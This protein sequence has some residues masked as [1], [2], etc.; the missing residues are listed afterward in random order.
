MG[1]SAGYVVGF[2]L[3]A[4]VCGH[5]AVRGTDRS[6]L[7][8]V[9]TMLVGE[10]CIYLPGVA[11][12]ALYVHLGLGTALALGFTPFVIGDAL[13]LALAAGLLPTAWWLTGLQREAPRSP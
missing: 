1:A 7:G 2:V 8:S 12:L 4:A 11:W 5:L 3:A 13:K 6:V 9:P 10:L